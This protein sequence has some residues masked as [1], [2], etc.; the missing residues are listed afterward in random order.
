MRV[1]QCL[2]IDNFSGDDSIS[3]LR[4]LQKLPFLEII[5]CENL[6]DAYN[7]LFKFSK[8]DFIIF[9]TEF[10]LDNLS[11]LI[12][13]VYAVPPIIVIGML[14]S[15]TIQA[16][17]FSQVVDALILPLEKT[18]L[19]RAIGRASNTKHTLN[20]VSDRDSVFIKLG[21]SMNRF[22]FD[23]IE[24]IEAYGIYSKV[25]Y[26]GVKM[27]VNESISNLEHLLPIKDF[28][29]IH[30]SYIVNIN[31]ILTID[32]G[33]LLLRTKKEKVPFGPKYKPLIN[34]L[35]KLHTAS[36]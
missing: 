33:G 17:D 22:Y 27:I 24:Y 10:G 14:P 16:L 11:E 30:K 3:Y 6:D 19:M 35:F 28:R 23:K 20:G 25:Y 26:E 18:R 8:I 2:V 12:R 32:S 31:N 36:S 1:M 7:K 15:S 29:R 34:A 4:I 9:N 13:Q 5:L 21:R